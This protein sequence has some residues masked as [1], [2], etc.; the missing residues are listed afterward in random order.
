MKGQL[1]EK[2]H[3]LRKRKFKIQAF[4]KNCDKKKIKTTFFAV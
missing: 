1:N 2:G 3:R 4:V